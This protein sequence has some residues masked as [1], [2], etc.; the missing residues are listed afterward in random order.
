M[1]D[2][3]RIGGKKIFDY[4]AQPQWNLGLFVTSEV[5]VDD[6]H[7]EK[8]GQRDKYHVQAEVRT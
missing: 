6:N 1:I 5:Q 2:M 7:R 4:P 8:R 3:K